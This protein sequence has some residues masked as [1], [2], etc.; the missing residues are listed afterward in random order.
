LLQRVGLEALA[1]IEAYLM[2]YRHQNIL[3]LHDLYRSAMSLAADPMNILGYRL[4]G[5]LVAVQAFYRYGRWMPHFTDP[6]V[7]PEVLR[8]MRRHSVR[9]ILGARAVVDPLWQDL[10]ALGYTLDYDEQGFLAYVNAALLRPYSEAGV[11]LATLEDVDAIARLRMAFD[12]EYFGTPAFQISQA[13]CLEIAEQYVRAGT[14]VAER[15]GEIVAMVATEAAIPGMTQIGA[16]FTVSHLRGQGLAR[17]VVSAIC[18]EKLQN[19]EKIVLVV[20]ES[21]QPALRA[22]ENLGFQRWEGYRMARFR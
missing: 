9:W 2:V 1:E 19:C 15:G 13:W 17:A 3:L 5:R 12:I 20:K 10:A 6:V 21:N 8:D 14:F 7:I 11:R 22:Y 18:Q 16:V 4:D